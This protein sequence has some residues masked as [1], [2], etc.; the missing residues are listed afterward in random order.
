MDEPASLR[1]LPT[2]VVES[3]WSWDAALWDDT[4]RDLSAAMARTI[5]GRRWFGAK[6]RS[7]ESLNIIEAAA[8][9]ATVRLLLARIRFSQGPDEVYQLALRFAPAGA[10]ARLG[11][12]ADAWMRVQAAGG[13]H[14]G[15]LYDALSDEE[16]CSQLLTWFETPSTLHGT[17]GELIAVETP[18]FK[19]VRS[20]RSD[21]LTARVVSAEQSNTSVVYGNRMILKMFRR[22][23]QGIH[24]D[25]EISAF[26]T[27]RNFANTPSVL[28]TLEYRGAH[29]ESWSLAMLQAYVPN[30]GDAWNFT[31]RRLGDA[32]A[33]ASL[34]KLPLP[35]G[36]NIFRTAERGIPSD[37][38]E[39][40]GDFLPRIELLGTRTAELHLALASDTSDPAFAPE[41]VSQGDRQRFSHRAT[42]EARATFVLLR[43]LLPRVSGELAQRA[44]RVLA[45]EG[46][47][48][49]RFEALAAARVDVTKIRCHGDYHLG[50]VLATADD[51]VII[52]FEGEPARPLAERREK[53]LALRDVAG[54][55]RSFHY[56]SRAAAAAVKAKAKSDGS[57]IDEWAQAWYAWT[58]A[59]YLG[60]Y[61]R[62]AGDASFV[63]SAHEDL[64]SVLDACLLDKAIY[65]L[66]YELNNRPDWV[67]LPLAA[68][69][70]LLGLR[71]G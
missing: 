51:F 6:T 62:A 41:P 7:I 48:I 30:Q 20:E 55:I 66:R 58:S 13:R 61:R 12:R 10:A 42:A 64:T 31:L 18:S 34:E 59:A 32:L 69:E 19:G 5:A 50:Q 38:R 60:A 37:V 44:E 28:G 43:D 65:E 67:Y 63:P 23:E 3:P 54:M 29:G 53:Q 46:A 35:P 17:H 40:I 24:P 68:L 15:L 47:A 4:R 26:L 1:N 39:A 71:R 9:S 70:E 56:A 45:F 52:D 21:P 49:S 16:F 11:Q 14:V 57:R 25:V 2:L 27:R 22:V 33:K 8:V 36:D